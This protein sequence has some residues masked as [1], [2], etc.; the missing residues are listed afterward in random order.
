[1]IAESLDSL[2]VRRLRGILKDRYGAELKIQHLV[3]AKVAQGDSSP[4]SFQIREGGRTLDVP[5]R[6]R[7]KFLASA[8]VEAARLLREDE[9]KGIAEM[10]C[11]VL[12]PTFYLWY[13]EQIE[14]NSSSGTEVTS[15]GDLGDFQVFAST[16]APLAG[17][18][19]LVESSDRL[20][21][22]KRAL[23]VHETHGRW[24]FIEI[25]SPEQ[26]RMIAADMSGWGGATI[27]L[28]DLH[29]LSSIAQRSLLHELLSN[30]SRY[31]QE[32]L[33]LLIVSHGEDESSPWIDQL[34]ALGAEILLDKALPKS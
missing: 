22:K 28:T 23:S 24:N 6:S 15:R 2:S 16:E 30:R 26:A 27:L 32:D 13:L 3:D 12:E 31:S 29:W 20:L 9:R 33:P 4:G 14:M 1:M 17:Q 19:Y 8:R 18:V 7:G 10:V 5:I 21:A 34:E 11:L 25:S